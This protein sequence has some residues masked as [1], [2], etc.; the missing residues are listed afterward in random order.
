MWSTLYEWALQALLLKHLD[1]NLK[2]Q[3]NQAGFLFLLQKTVKKK[4]KKK[5]HAFQVQK[6]FIFLLSNS[7]PLYT[8]S[9]RARSSYL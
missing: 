7:A 3:L 4:E 5:F 2:D 6:R 8:G 9:V 1:T